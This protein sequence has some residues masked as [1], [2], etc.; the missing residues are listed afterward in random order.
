MAFMALKRKAKRRVALID[1]SSPRETSR[2]TPEQREDFADFI[3]NCYHEYSRQMASEKTLE[4][5]DKV[6]RIAQQ[7]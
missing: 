2:L 6:D 7:E 4:T 5:N 3:L 1:R